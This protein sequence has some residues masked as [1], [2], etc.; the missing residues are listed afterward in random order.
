MWHWAN[1]SLSGLWFVCKMTIM[2][3]MTLRVCSNSTIQ[4]L[5]ISEK[6]QLFNSLTVQ[7]SSGDHETTWIQDPIMPLPC[8][9]TL[10]IVI[11]HFT[12]QFD[13]ATESPD[14]QWNVIPGVSVRVFLDKVKTWSSR[15]VVGFIQSTEGLDRTKTLR[16]NSPSLSACLQADTSVPPAGRPRLSREFTPSALLRLRSFDSVRSIPLAL[17]SLSSLPTADLGSSQPP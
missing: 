5:S 1:K 12:C 4:S 9:V 17:L 7:R 14:V 16:E 3:L 13:W 2:V 6:H 8:P 11:I 15:Q 10:G